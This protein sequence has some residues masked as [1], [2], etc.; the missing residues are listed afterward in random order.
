M[1]GF[2]DAGLL[3]NQVVDLGFDQPNG[4]VDRLQRRIDLIGE[5]GGLAAGFPIDPP[6]IGQ[7]L[8]D[9]RF[10]FGILARAAN[11]HL[12]AAGGDRQL[13]FVGAH[14]FQCVLKVL[15][16]M[17]VKRQPKFG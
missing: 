13:L 15:G 11:I 4:V 1:Q 2:L 5:F 9:R 6:D 17:H 3:A 14:D 16:D 12:I 10:R 7:E 8:I